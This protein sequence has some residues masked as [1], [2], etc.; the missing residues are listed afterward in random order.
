MIHK[1]T[2]KAKP[3][4]GEETINGQPVH[5]I[6]ISRVCFKIGRITVPPALALAVNGFTAHPTMLP[7]QVKK[8]GDSEVVWAEGGQGSQWAEPEHF[9]RVKDLMHFGRGG[10]PK[11]LKKFLCGG[12]REEKENAGP[13]WWE[14]VFED[15]ETK[16]VANLDL[17][18][19]VEGNLLA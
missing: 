14:Q 12:W 5:T 18:R 19:P 16:R 3:K 10:N 1:F 2:S 9:E 6:A 15:L 4:E 11:A 7:G 13:V 17:V 8:E